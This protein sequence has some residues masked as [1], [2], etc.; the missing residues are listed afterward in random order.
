[1]D[2]WFVK[3]NGGSSFRVTVQAK[4]LHYL[5]ADPGL[6]HY[7]DLAHPRTNPGLQSRTLVAHARRETLAGT[8]CH[9]FYILYNPRSVT[10]LSYSPSLPAFNGVSI[11]DGYV[12]A[13]H[14]AANKSGNRFPITA[15]RYDTLS[16]MMSNLHNLLCAGAGDIPLPEEIA[17][18]VELLWERL[19]RTGALPLAAYRRRP[20]A[21]DGAPNDILRLVH[22]RGARDD[23]EGVW[24]RRDTIV[25]IADD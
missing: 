25:F 2:W 24:S 5:Q 6:W 8:S 22:H 20:T 14:I 11:L 4:I 19:K 16:P 1:M 12:A 10:E 15:K 13:A 3:A 18:R 17:G 9:P 7:E 21:M 23:D